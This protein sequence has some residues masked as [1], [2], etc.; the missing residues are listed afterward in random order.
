MDRLNFNHLRCFWAVARDGS[1]AA[2]CRRLGLTQPTI[3][4]QISDLEDAFDATLFRR[5]GR[6]LL[7]TDIGRTVYA[8]AD[9]IFALGQEL[10][11]AV[12]GQPT[13][14][15]ALLYV[16][17]SDVAPKLLTRL[18]LEPALRMEPPARL[19]CREGKTEALLADLALSGLDAVLTD[20]PL[21]SGSRIKAFN[22]KLGG[23]QISVYGVPRVAEGRRAG[24]PESL[25]GAP[26]LLPTG[27]TTLRRSL[28]AWFERHG[29]RPSVVAEFEDS[30]LLKTFAAAGHGLFAA[31]TVIAD[32]IESQFGVVR[33]GELEGVT[34]TLYIVTVE[35]RIGHP[36]VQAVVEAAR[37]ALAG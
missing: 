11:D 10:R 15:P 5:V 32:A 8:Y 36:A 9:D 3:S 29:V 17:V 25:D 28:D 6:R 19:I 2:A 35:R 22:H 21:P 18:V 37:A 30:A 4:K 24:F 23:S 34:E 16:G 1:V 7:L 14:K 26:L 20:S 12:R 31:P 27:N 33:L 13:S